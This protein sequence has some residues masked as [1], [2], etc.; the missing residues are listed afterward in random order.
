[1][2]WLKRRRRDHRTDAT[3]NKGFYDLIKNIAVCCQNHFSFLGVGYADRVD[4]IAP[5][6]ARV[7]AVPP[8]G[9]LPQQS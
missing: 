4:G 7:T 8:N 1:V 5:L 2:L 3:R 9:G 6:S